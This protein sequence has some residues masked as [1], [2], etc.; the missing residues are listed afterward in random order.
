[1]M[2]A[3][4]ASASLYNC[5]PN[6]PTGG[7]S[8][9]Q[10]LNSR[11]GLDSWSN[12]VIQN[13]SNGAGRFKLFTMN[14]LGGIGP[15]NSQFGGRFNRADGIQ[16]KSYL[17]FPKAQGTEY[18]TDGNSTTQISLDGII[19]EGILSGIG[20]NSEGLAYNNGSTIAT[21]SWSDLHIKIEDI[22]ALSSASN[23]FT[24]NVNHTIQIQNDETTDSTSYIGLSAYANKLQMNLYHGVA[25][26][27]NSGD[28]LTSGGPDGSMQWLPGSTLKGSYE[29][30]P[31]DSSGR[32]SFGQTFGTPP[33]VTISQQTTGLIIPLT[34]TDITE[35]DFGWSSSAIGI[36]RI[37]WST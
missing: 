2:G 15:G 31:I 33:I 4:N 9:K 37:N 1:M 19:I 24:L 35:T 23:S 12:P 14:Q 20:F 5:D 8:K 34:I 16:S 17:E 30:N 36:G 25:N 22:Q 28:V 13:K 6:E 29:V 7:G 18:W 32:I 10:G 27:G 3:G 21:L 26:F 11:V